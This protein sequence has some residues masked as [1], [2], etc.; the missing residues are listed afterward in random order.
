MGRWK[1]CPFSSCTYPNPRAFPVSPPFFSLVFSVFT[2]SSPHQ[3][4]R[5]R[6]QMNQILHAL[7]STFTT[8]ACGSKARHCAL[9]QMAAFVDSDPSRLLSPSDNVDLGPLIGPGKQR[10]FR[11]KERLPFSTSIAA[12]P[13]LV[14]PR[15]RNVSTTKVNVDLEIG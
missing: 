13:T 3:V 4:Q 6:H 2:Q 12:A 5:L 9:N 7:S 15:E 8:C 14:F 10:G 11:T 1:C